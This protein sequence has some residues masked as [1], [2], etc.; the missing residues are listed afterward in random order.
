MLLFSFLLLPLLITWFC[1][2]YK[3]RKV[4]SVIVFGAFAAILVCGFRAFFTFSHRVIPYDFT[5]IFIYFLTL[6]NEKACI[7]R[8]I[9]R[10]E[11]GKAP[12]DEHKSSQG[13]IYL[14]WGIMCVLS[15]KS[16]PLRGFSLMRGA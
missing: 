6:F 14:R 9:K 10:I 5:E 1:F 8:Q 16:V 2:Y 13:A 3:N 4:S 15:K 12:C 11:K 7:K